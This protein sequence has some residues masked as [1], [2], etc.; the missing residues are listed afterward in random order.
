MATPRKRPTSK[1][2]GTTPLDEQTP[3]EAVAHAIVVKYSDLAPSLNRIMAADIGE[4]GR[5]HAITLFQQSL[6]VP[7][8]PNRNPA[9]AIEAGR[10]F[11]ASM[12]SK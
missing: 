9:I 8:D 1:A 6:G 7:G 12:S 4:E 3:S 10:S 2:V 5:L 11:A